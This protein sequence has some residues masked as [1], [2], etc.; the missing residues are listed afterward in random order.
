MSEWCGVEYALRGTARRDGDL[1]VV[2]A[3]IPGARD[4]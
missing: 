1:T 3:L 4:E 2:P